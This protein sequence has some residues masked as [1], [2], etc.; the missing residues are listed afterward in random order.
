MRVG[1]LTV[2]QRELLNGWMPGAETVCD[3]SWGL[4][5]TTVLEL[6]HD[7]GRYIAK[8]GDTDDHHI[9]R[10]LHA[11]RAW[12]GPW[13]SRGRAPSLVHAD[14]DAKLL[15]TG[16][17]PGDLLLGHPDEFEPDLYRQAGAL[18][19]ALHGQ[20][21][22]HDP[23]FE[24]RL[25]AKVT[26]A[27]DGPHRIAPDVEARLRADVAS[28]PMPVATLVPTHGDWHPRNWLVRDR[29]LSVIDFGR[30]ELRPALSDLVRLAAQQFHAAPAL[31][32][33]FLD[34]YGSDPREPGAWRRQRMLE[35]VG[36]AT[37]AYQVGDERFE[38]QGHRMIA[39]VLADG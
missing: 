12:L 28:W 6:L 15:V 35:A 16:Y 5:G 30:A 37:W 29:V 24:L 34:G 8:A 22:V 3:R 25:R 20:Q 11:H 39:D 2:R 31:E 26:R 7:G 19:A 10:E 14:D 38:Q 4:V 33:A 21:E 23:Q 18:L 36:T 9:A 32:S 27:L 13:T 17:L 1:E